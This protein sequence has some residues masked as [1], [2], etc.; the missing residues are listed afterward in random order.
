MDNQQQKNIKELWLQYEN[1]KKP[2][3]DRAK[4]NAKLTLPVLFPDENASGTT[5]FETPFQSLGA[6]GVSNLSSKFMLTL[7]PVGFPPFRLQMDD[8]TLEE[9]TKDPALRG[10][11][12]QQLASY[13]R[14]VLTN[15]EATNFRAKLDE[16]FRHLIVTGNGCLF[17]NEEGQCTFFNLYQFAT[18][19]SPDGTLI[20]L[21]IKQKLHPEAIEDE[22]LRAKL[23]TFTDPTRPYVE[24][25]TRSYLE[26]GV[27]NVY[28]QC[29]DENVGT[30][31]KFKPDDFPFIAPLLIHNSGE[32]YGRSYVEEHK[33]DLLSYE[34]LSKCFLE[35][36]AQASRFISLVDPTGTVK[37]KQLAAAQSGDYIPGRKDEVIPL[38]TGKAQDFGV[39]M[40]QFPIIEK[41]L[42]KAFLL[43]DGAVRDSERTT[44][45]EI[46]ATIQSLQE[47][48]A[49][50]FSSLSQ[51]LQL[52]VI[53][54][55][56]A[57]LT[58]K[59]LLPV[60]PK[61]TVKPRITTGIDAIGRGQDYNKLAA[62][63]Q[64]VAGI[65]PQPP[66]EVTIGEYLL[67][68]A[69]ALGI[70]P[71]G[72]IKSQEEL[73]AMQ[74]EAQNAQMMQSIAPQIA[75]NVSRGMMDQATQQQQQQAQQPQ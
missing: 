18:K 41:R 50:I 11:I 22:T 24:L 17:I 7:F 39:I 44:A 60:L 43:L 14:A 71:N 63:M 55:Y 8:F 6:D 61:E 48:R 31:G 2:Y 74:Q 70:D 68:I 4:D 52:Q 42:S 20:D 33:G 57:L 35:F 29:Q 16:L 49:G 75:G 9:L 30:P 40:A 67:R 46:Q 69:T 45:T 47:A 15:M 10:Q 3:L 23:K 27:W 25:Y 59:K 66:A 37:P 36:A 12:E 34:K 73:Q 28:Q 5:A 65:P 1:T 26:N 51:S 64:T 58:K 56:I 19:R 72:L 32:D 62:F 53:R 21:I 38:E 13:E 54:R